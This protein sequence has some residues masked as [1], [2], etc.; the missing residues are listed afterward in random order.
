MA[1][2]V[3]AV[4]AVLFALSSTVFGPRAAGSAGS[5]NGRVLLVKG[6]APRADASNAS[7]GR[8]PVSTNAPKA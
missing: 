3:F 1:T 7:S 5:V 4:G 2:R 6:G 8:R